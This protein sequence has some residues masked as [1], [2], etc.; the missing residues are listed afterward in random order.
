MGRLRSVDYD[1]QRGAI[2]DCAAAVFA[3]QGFSATSISDIAAACNCSRSRLYHYFVS[4]EALLY[5]TLQTHV[6]LLLARC[7]DLSLQGRSGE[8]QLG[9]AIA[10]F[11]EV[12]AVSR[13]RHVVMLTCLDAL[14]LAQRRKIVAKQRQLIEFVTAILVRIHPVGQSVKLDVMLLFGMMNW[15]HTW[16]NPD[17]PALPKDVA[18]RIVQLFLH[19]YA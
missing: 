12:Y 5:E 9:C 15:T 11:L 14:P 13:D 7:A 4:K 2:I 1:L 10:M 16:Y 8:E 19:G 18:A 3:Q 17:G 6:D